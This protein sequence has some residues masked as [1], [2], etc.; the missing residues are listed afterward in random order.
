MHENYCIK[1]CQYTVSDHKQVI[2]KFSNRLYGVLIFAREVVHKKITILILSIGTE[3][4]DPDN[5][6]SDQGLHC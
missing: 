4:V 5:G 3:G 1:L 6:V 2:I